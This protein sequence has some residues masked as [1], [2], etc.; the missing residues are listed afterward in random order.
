MALKGFSFLMVLCVK[1]LE[2]LVK[3]YLG[4]GYQKLFLGGV[5][6]GLVCGNNVVQKRLPLSSLL[7][8]FL[9]NLFCDGIFY[10]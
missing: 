10:L 8:N 1:L 5:R 6:L 4:G 9:S 2:M 3:V 7:M